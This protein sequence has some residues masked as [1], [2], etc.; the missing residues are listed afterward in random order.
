MI[1][2]VL[3]DS[4]PSSLYFSVAKWAEVNKHDW[5]QG[6]CKGYV[7]KSGHEKLTIFSGS[8]RGKLFFQ[9]VVTAGCSLFK[10]NTNIQNIMKNMVFVHLHSQPNEP[11][12]QITKMS[13]NV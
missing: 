7:L 13:K 1:N 5:N 6:N 11:P 12:F 9:L 10:E 2:N 3:F 8:C 4:K